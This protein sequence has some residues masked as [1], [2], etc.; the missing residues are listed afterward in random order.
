[1]VLRIGS[2]VGMSGPVILPGKGTLVYPDIGGSNVVSW[3]KSP[4]VSCVILEIISYMDD[5]TWAKLAKVVA[6]GI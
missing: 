6:P 2:M 1:M 3:Y 4:E 5:E